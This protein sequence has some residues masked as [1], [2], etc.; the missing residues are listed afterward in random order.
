MD[1][2]VE[3]DEMD[4][5]FTRYLFP[6]TEVR[7]NL[8]L[9]LLE[10]KNDEVL[11]WGYELYFSGFQNETFEYLYSIF[12]M[13]YKDENLD[14]SKR[15]DSIKT[16][17]YECVEYVIKEEEFG[18]LLMNLSKRNYDLSKFIELFF[19][20]TCLRKENT[21]YKKTKFIIK[22][23]TK[24]IDKYRSI[25]IGENEK[26]NNVLKNIY[27]YPLRKEYNEL[28]D[29]PVIGDYD[30]RY[31][32]HWLKYTYGCPLWENRVAQYL[33]TNN[34]EY[35]YNHDDNHDEDDEYNDNE[36]EGDD[37]DKEVEN[38]VLIIDDEPQIIDNWTD[39]IH[40][41]PDEFYNNFGYEPDEQPLNIQNMVI[42][43][44]DANINL[45]TF[46]NNFGY[47]LVM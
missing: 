15:F 28:F 20:K 32:V 4:F 45:E 41:L 35:N 27:V 39:K 1:E 10:H 17:I 47:E 3:G 33:D 2:M 38:I 31:R 19:G 8:F 22:I 34:I 36:E 14:L 16:R 18:S 12:E 26:A 42:G 5:I 25:E 30:E 9:C 37:D 24:D 13:M 44:S 43:K 11:Y 29:L 7:Q 6:K 40:H 46:C 23:T 21:P